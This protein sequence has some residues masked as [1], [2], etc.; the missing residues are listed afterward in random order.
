ML[1]ILLL[2][3]IVWSSLTVRFAEQVF[4]G[5]TKAAWLILSVAMVCLNVYGIMELCNA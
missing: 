2:L 3:L 5:R 4:N 1:F